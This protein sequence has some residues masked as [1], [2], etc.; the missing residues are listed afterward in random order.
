MSSHDNNLSMPQSSYG[1][2]DNN[3]DKS[4]SSDG[5]PLLLKKKEDDDISAKDD[6]RG[7]TYLHIIIYAIINVIIAV[8]GLIGYASVIFNHPSFQPHMA[9][10]AKLVIFSSFVHQLA[11][12]LFSS[13]SF[14]IGT[15]QD[16]GLIFLSAM[17]NTIA[18]AILS[19]GGSV[20]EVISTTLVVLPLG[21]ATL[22]LV[23]MLLGKF[24]LL[25]IVSYLPMPVIGGYLAFIGYF[26]LEAGVALCIGKS[27]TT[28]S[29]WAYLLEPHSLLLATPGLL[30]ALILTIISRKA[31]NDAILP[32]A[33]VAIPAFFYLILFLCSVTLDEARDSGWIG[34]ET[35]PVSPKELIHLVDFNLVHWSM[36]RE[37][38]GTWVGMLFVVAF[39]SCL[40]IAAVSID[41]GK[42]LDTNKEMVTV[43]AANFMSG[44]FFGFTGKLC[45]DCFSSTICI[46]IYYAYNL[47]LAGVQAHTSSLKQY[48]HIELDVTLD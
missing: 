42:P 26:C 16:A 43:G 4:I 40:D 34:E 38:M 20:E 17:A 47:T 2:I 25:D 33:M 1:A 24:R 14:A 29:D 32:T 48:S 8:P 39:A 30:A 7:Y 44:C 15:V 6:D 3:S 41:M 13:L 28:I 36:I 10:L 9:E 35:P 18:N 21:T 23:L 46:N 12:T 11:F 37:C 31:T 27:M 5:L 22:G 19:E 45:F